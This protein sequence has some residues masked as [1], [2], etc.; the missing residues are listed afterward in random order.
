MIGGVF[1]FVVSPGLF[2]ALLLV[3]FFVSVVGRMAT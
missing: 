1:A 2:A 3:G